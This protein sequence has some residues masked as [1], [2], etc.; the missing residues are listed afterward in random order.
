M[1]EVD[2]GMVEAND[3]AGSVNQCPQIQ[4]LPQGTAGEGFTCV[5]VFC[6]K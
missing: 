4:W 3:Y 5:V 2:E 6:A 1:I